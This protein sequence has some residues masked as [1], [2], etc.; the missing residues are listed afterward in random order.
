MEHHPDCPVIK[1]QKEAEVKASQES[2][3]YFY[4]LNFLPAQGTI[5]WDID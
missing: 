3:R 1:E 5:N 4:K 2:G